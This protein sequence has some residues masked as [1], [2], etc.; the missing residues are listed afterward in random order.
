MSLIALPSEV[1][2]QILDGLMSWTAIELWKTGSLVLAAKLRNGGIQRV[3]LQ[4][5]SC[6]EGVRWPRCLKEFQLLSLDVDCTS[7]FLDSPEDIRKEL[8]QLKPSLK[9]LFLFIDSAREIVFPTNQADRPTDNLAERTASSPATKLAK[10]QENQSTALHK[11]AWDLNLTLPNLEIF[12]LK[13]KAPFT[14]FS[15]HTITLLPQSLTSL[16]L[17]NAS[18]VDC[19]ALPPCLTSF[20]L[21]FGVIQPTDIPLLPKSL[22]QLSV[23]DPNTL[24]YL[25]F[26]PLILPNL[27]EISQFPGEPVPVDYYAP[28]LAKWPVNVLTARVSPT[29]LEE[30]DEDEEEEDKRCERIPPR[31]ETV[32][33]ASSLTL[34]WAEELPPSVTSLVIEYGIKDIVQVG[35]R[36]STS[37][38]NLVSIDISTDISFSAAHCHLLP[39]SLTSLRVDNFR[40]LHH[41]LTLHFTED[42]PEE[43]A[44]AKGA[45]LIQGA[46]HQR[47]TNIKA[48]L[49]K[50]NPKIR[51]AATLNAYFELVES[52]ALFG[53]PLGLKMLCIHGRLHRRRWPVLLPPLI[54]DLQFNHMDGFSRPDFF[55]HLPPFLQTMEVILPH[56]H[57]EDE[58]SVWKFPEIN[59][60]FLN[61]QHLTNITLCIAA[62]KIAETLLPHLPRNLLLLDLDCSHS[63][64]TAAG[65]QT[66]PPH[67]RVL[68]LACLSIKPTGKWVSSLPRSII[69][70]ATIN[71]LDGPDL[72]NCPPSI[73]V[74]VAP[75]KHLS[76][77]SLLSLPR[78]LSQ[79]SL[80]P[81]PRTR[82]DD[83]A[84]NP[85]LEPVLLKFR[86]FWRIFSH[87]EAEIA[88]MLQLPDQPVQP[89]PK[90]SQAKK[91]K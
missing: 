37:L 13:D 63:P 4:R 1:L 44:R 34:P 51:S 73:E 74:L 64:F 25:L 86:P 75:V 84:R 10:G 39:R 57:I 60:S 91:K 20:T 76:V 16:T 82:A 48:D 46:D 33:F 19:G 81:A 71:S 85:L 55:D 31:A 66:L 11:E 69:Q 32:I 59:H 28:Q 83:L 56:H 54:T 49:L 62:T 53:L 52:G 47:W 26:N 18:S 27:K 5:V 65:L 79:F 15:A 3:K 40:M 9:K 41:I 70:L 6:S 14:R 21:P 89:K 87:S 17:S 72:R 43:E 45:E 38:L 24:E 36:I 12:S 35:R 30:R 78:S 77:A 7:L 58:L 67:L 50:I 23:L 88:E 90:K 29:V 68:K 22:T 8:R 61:M 42:T 2:A 80:L